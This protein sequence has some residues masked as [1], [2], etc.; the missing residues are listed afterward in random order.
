MKTTNHSQTLRHLMCLVSASLLLGCD[1]RTSLSGGSPTPENSAAPVQV[2][3]TTLPTVTSRSSSMPADCFFYEP[4]DVTIV[5]DGTDFRLRIRGGIIG[6]EVFSSKQEAIA[7][8]YE[9]K[10]I[11]NPAAGK[12]YQT[13]P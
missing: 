12:N 3:T 5:T 1:A 7:Y 2:P 8:I 10:K 4:G 9:M 11:M 6:S 13:A